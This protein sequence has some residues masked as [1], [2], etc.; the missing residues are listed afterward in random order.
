M[1]R[2]RE[3]GK[4]A[5]AET[6]HLGSGNRP[7]LIV[8]LC[9]RGSRGWTEDQAM[10]DW[11]QHYTRSTGL[12]HPG[13]ETIV[14]TEDKT[15]LGEVLDKLD[16]NSTYEDAPFNQSPGNFVFE[17]LDKDYWNRILENSKDPAEIRLA[18]Q[19]LKE[20]SDMTEEAKQTAKEPQE[21]AKQTGTRGFSLGDQANEYKSTHDDL[22][23][24]ALLDAEMAGWR[25]E[26]GEKLIGIIA[27]MEEAGHNSQYGVYPLITVRKA[28]GEMV[29][30]H[31]F[32]H[33]VREALKHKNP[34]IGDR[35]GAKYLGKAKSSDFEYDNY[36][37]VVEH[38][39]GLVPYQR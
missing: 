32:H 2:Q 31:A 35:I 9:G 29:A 19:K 8:C 34:R 10:L 4:H 22:D 11:R 20:I 38:Q 28:D 15:E 26:V 23:M 14:W 30:W 27:N 25:P 36:K 7:F 3:L 5:V 12:E 16:I 39:I 24:D 1:T 37:V 6:N 17:E 18:K 21:E 13:L 33:V